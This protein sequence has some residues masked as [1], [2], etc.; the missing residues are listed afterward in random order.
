[1]LGIIVVST[2]LR[3]QVALIDMMMDGIW[4]KKVESEL[5]SRSDLLCSH[6]ISFPLQFNVVFLLELGTAVL[7]LSVYLVCDSS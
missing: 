1:V 4:T 2:F 7:G 6:D 5:Q 3:Y